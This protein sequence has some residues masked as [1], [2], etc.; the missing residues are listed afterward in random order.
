MLYTTANKKQE[1]GGGPAS[2][3]RLYSLQLSQHKE[4]AWTSSIRLYY[5]TRVCNTNDAKWACC[6]RSLNVG[7]LDM[8]PKTSFSCCS[9]ASLSLPLQ[10][11]HMCYTS[12]PSQRLL[13]N[14]FVLNKA[15]VIM[16]TTTTAIIS[17][18]II[19]NENDTFK[20]DAHLF[21][22]FCQSHQLNYICVHRTAF[23]S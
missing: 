1:T 22:L 8:I 3:T 6:W 7:F 16:T 4:V 18:P 10:Q 17:I 9:F 13:N 23:P 2:G 20:Y 15:S 5:D 11:A 14:I 12:S 19:I 21:E